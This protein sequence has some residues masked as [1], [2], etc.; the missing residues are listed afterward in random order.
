MPTTKLAVHYDSG[1]LP[2]Y[3]LEKNGTVIAGSNAVIAILQELI[4]EVKKVKSGQII[5]TVDIPATR[6]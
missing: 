3:L 6:V 1:I 4:S 5:V 2:Q